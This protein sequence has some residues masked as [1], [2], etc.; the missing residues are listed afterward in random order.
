MTCKELGGTCDMRLSAETWQGM[1]ALM[2]NHPRETPGRRAEYG[3][4]D[5]RSRRMDSGSEEGMGCNAS[6]T[7][8][9]WLV[10]GL[11]RSSDS[12]FLGFPENVLVLVKPANA[13]VG[14]D[15]FQVTDIFSISRVGFRH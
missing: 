1:A 10:Q 14:N 12:S 9:Q 5:R 15:R 6:G 3:R 2:M 7:A 8:A 13:V 4:D 11:I